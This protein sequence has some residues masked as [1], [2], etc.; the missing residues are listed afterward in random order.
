M[1]ALHG[2]GLQ[3]SQLSHTLDEASVLQDSQKLDQY[4]SADSRFSLLQRTLSQYEKS[5]P[6]KELV[7]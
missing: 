1:S 2:Q 6:Y 3:L 7:E 4:S 5:H